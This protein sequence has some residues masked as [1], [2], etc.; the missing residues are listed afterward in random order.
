[1]GHFNVWTNDPFIYKS[2]VSGIKIYD[3]ETGNLLNFIDYEN[4]SSVWANG[5]YVYIATSVSGIYHCPVSTVT[6]TVTLESYKQ[7][8]EIT[9]NDGWVVDTEISHVKDRTYFREFLQTEFKNE[10]DK[11]TLLLKTVGVQVGDTQ[12]MLILV[13]IIFAHILSMVLV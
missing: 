13:M 4:T 5:D 11:T 8:P 2:T 10:K 12:G 6:G 3:L 9:N 1:M 7:Y